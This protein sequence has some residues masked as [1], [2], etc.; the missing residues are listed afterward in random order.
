LL[1]IET[2]ETTAIELRRLP[3]HERDAFLSEAANRAISDYQNDS[4]LTAFDAFREEDLH[5]HSSNA[6]PG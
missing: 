3:T 1:E 5:G 6:E 4:D 2:R